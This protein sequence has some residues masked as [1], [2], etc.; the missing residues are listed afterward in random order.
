M[1]PFA[2]AF[3]NA[4]AWIGSVL[5]VSGGVKFY[6]AFSSK[7]QMVEVNQWGLCFIPLMLLALFAPNQARTLHFTKTITPLWQR[8]VASKTAVTTICIVIASIHFLG[9]Y[10]RYISFTANWDLAI[11]ANACA[12]GLHSSLRNNLSLLADHFE[13]ALALAGPICNSADPAIAL[14]L[15]QI[16]AWCIGAWGLRSLALLLKWAPGYVA[17][18]Q[19]LYLLFA[20]NQT[21]SY[22]DFHLY[23]WSL[24]TIPWILYAI[25]SRKNLLLGV[26]VLLHLTLKENTGLFVGGLGLWMM[27]HGRKKTGLV[28]AVFGAAAF[29][30]IMKVAYPYFRGGAESEYFTKYYGYLGNDFSSFLRTSLTQPWIP[31]KALL[32]AGRLRYY[33]TIFA[34]FLFFPLL[35]PSYVLPILGVL[36]INALSS[37]DFLYSAGYHYE[38]EIY[39][40]FFASMIVLLKDDRVVTRWHSLIKFLRVSRILNPEMAWLTVMAV[41]F[42]GVTPPGQVLYYAPSKTQ[43]TL[44]TE[45]RKLSRQ[46]HDCSVATVDRVTPHLSD[47]PQLLTM[48]HLTEANAVIVAYPQGDRLWMSNA[49]QIERDIAPKLS[50]TFK[51]AQPLNYDANFRVWTRAPCVLK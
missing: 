17:C 36:L 51:L 24:A 25:Q 4:L 28:V 37:N 35:A 44:H 33:A 12:N 31:L 2:S 3:A 50:Q 43:A 22:Y 47:I 11:Y 10:N 16:V 32:E 18:A 1:L 34:P 6:A 21:I 46:L 8:L 48:D 45:L 14:L 19:I 38:A 30:F 49:D 41:F 29:V 26:L 27:F 9:L 5:F 23:G 15:T 42:S 39:P 13:P 40:W 7:P 20:G